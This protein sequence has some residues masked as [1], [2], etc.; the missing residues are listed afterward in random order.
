MANQINVREEIVDQFKQ[1]DPMHDTFDNI[2]G[3]EFEGSYA[4]YEADENFQR[5]VGKIAKNVLNKIDTPLSEV[6]ENEEFYIDLLSIVM[7]VIDQVYAQGIISAI[8]I[9]EETCEEWLEGITK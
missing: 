4:R 2:E 1:L 9:T 5:F 6:G 3:F 7:D 8:P